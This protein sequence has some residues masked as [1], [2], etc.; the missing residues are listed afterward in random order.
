MK[1]GTAPRR[2]YVESKRSIRRHIEKVTLGPRVEHPEY[3]YYLKVRM[4][5]D[6]QKI[7]L[8]KS[9]CGFQ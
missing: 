1:G 4:L 8:G 5:K 6:N 3:W 2:L 9:R 7:E